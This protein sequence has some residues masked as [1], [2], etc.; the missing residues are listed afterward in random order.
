MGMFDQEGYLYIKDRK[1]D[2][3]ISGGEN[4]YP[5]EVEQ[6]LFAHPQIQEASCIG[7]PDLQFGEAVM[8]VVV[9]KAGQSL[10]E[11]EVIEYTSRHLAKFKVPKRVAFIGALPR[12]AVGKVLRRELRRQFGGMTVKY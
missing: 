11:A 2:M 5:A 7:I 6:V 9:P 12:S 10:S 8:A 3:V 4:I 1:K